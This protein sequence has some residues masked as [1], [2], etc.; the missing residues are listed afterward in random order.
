MARAPADLR[1][2]AEAIVARMSLDERVAA[3]SGRD[4]W[5]RHRYRRAS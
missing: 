3:V 4:W 1:A 2:E 5:T